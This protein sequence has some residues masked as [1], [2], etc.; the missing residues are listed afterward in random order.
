MAQPISGAAWKRINGTAIGTTTIVAEPAVLHSI[1]IGTSV[2]GT[3]DFYDDATGSVTGNFMFTMQNTGGS[4]PQNVIVDAQ[5]KN[6]LS[7]VKSGTTDMMV[8][9]Y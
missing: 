8:T 5:L 6:G 9:I 7:Y 4:V 1:V 3:V 2:T